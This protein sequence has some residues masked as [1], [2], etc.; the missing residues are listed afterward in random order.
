[1]K[2]SDNFKNAIKTTFYDKEIVL[3]T[4]SATTDADGWTTLDD[5]TVS[6]SFYGNI[7][8]VRASD[9]IRQPKGIVIDYYLVLTTDRGGIEVG[10]ILGWNGEKYQVKKVF[11][12]DSHYEYGLEGW[13]AQSSETTSA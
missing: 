3:Y 8:H 7:R 11:T 10:N 12:F 2:I 4:T 13:E 5:S 9:E 6:E 1:M